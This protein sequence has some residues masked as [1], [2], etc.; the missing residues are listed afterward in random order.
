M[1]FTSAWWMASSLPKLIMYN[2]DYSPSGIT[3]RLKWL[4]LDFS[5]TGQNFLGTCSVPVVEDQ[6]WGLIWPPTHPEIQ[7]IWKVGDCKHCRPQLWLEGGILESS[8]NLEDT[9]QC[10]STAELVQ[11]VL[12]LQA[13]RAS[14]WVQHPFLLAK[15][16]AGRSHDSSMVLLMS[17]AIVAISAFLVP[18]AFSVR[19][20]S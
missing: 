18:I 20:N 7:Q 4:L 19:K 5:I 8:Q 15:E 14:S 6:M 10:V 17:R 2:R 1:C 16:A 12:S 3:T 9:S 13:G 11:E